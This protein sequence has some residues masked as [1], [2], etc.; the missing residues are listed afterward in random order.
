MYK[1]LQFDIQALDNLKLGKFERDT[2][3]E[4]THSYIPGSVIKG[5]IVWGL[6]QR[7]GSVPKTFLNGDT[8]FYNA[9]PII[10]ENTTVPMM[11]GYV[12]N[13][14]EIR[15]KRDEVQIKHSFNN[16][17][18]ENVIPYNNYEFIAYSKSSTHVLGYNPKKIENLHINKKDAENDNSDSKMFRYEAV[19]KG[20]CFRSYIR[21]DENYI[22]D[23]NEILKEVIYFG[24]SRGSGYGK[25]KISN[26]KCI[27]NVQM[28]Y[29][30]MDIRDNIYI[31]FLSD[32]ILYY[33]GRVN[34]Y[35]PP[36]VLK[37]KLGIKGICEYL[38]SY[39]NLTKAST[40]NTMYNTNTVCYSAV[41]KGSVIKYRIEEKIEPE[42][43]RELIAKGVGIRKEDGYGQI[44]ILN[45]IQDNLIVSGYT[46]EENVLGENIGLKDEDKDIM[47]VILNNIF[48]KRV[49][50]LVERLVIDMLNGNNV[51]ALITCGCF[52][53]IA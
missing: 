18:H 5:A 43:I 52:Y 24:G 25:C 14:Q 15:S 35:I 2:N 46:R 26:I 13:K 8:I 16:T 9:Y 17:A 37:V 22:G 45:S 4:Y 28:H 27:S 49:K 32:A 10:N 33:N 30:D 40:F 48:N 38:K 1:Y 44:A 42:K 12:G 23:I 50:L 39:A 21:I 36:E 41:S 7:N 11:Q 34:T 6:V 20:E 3:N 47:N 29:S 31:Y 53:Q 19:K 51:F